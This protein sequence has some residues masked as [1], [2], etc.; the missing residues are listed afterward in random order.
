[1]LAMKLR[2]QL[3]VVALGFSLF[4]LAA[5]AVSNAGEMSQKIVGG[6]EAGTGEFPFIVSLQRGSHFCGGSLIASDWVLTAAHCVR[7]NSAVNV[8][9]GLH[10]QKNKANADTIASKRIIVHPQYNQSTMVWDFALIQ[11]SRPTSFQPIALNQGEINVEQAGLTT[12]TAGWGVTREGSWSLP[13]LLQKVEVPLVTRATCNAAYSN[14]ITES[15]VCAG[16]EA[17]GKDACQGDSGGPLIVETASRDR[18]LVGV[19]SWGHG[20]ARPNKYGVYSNV[21]EAVSWIHS[22]LSLPE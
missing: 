1:M 3:V 4:S 10:D 7:G 20:C 12:V 5:P 19:V 18:Y 9:I 22:T 15:M 8:V 21:Q 13:D 16:F 14:K 6:V 11:L 2:N 17:G